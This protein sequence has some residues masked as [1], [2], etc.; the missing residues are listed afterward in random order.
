MTPEIERLCT[1]IAE[2]PVA[3]VILGQNNYSKALL[4]NELLQKP[5]LPVEKEGDTRTYWCLIS[6]H[7]GSKH[8]TAAMKKASKKLPVEVTLNLVDPQRNDLI[9]SGKADLEKCPFK[10]MSTFCGRLEIVEFQCQCHPN[11]C[12][13]YK[14][15]AANSLVVHGEKGP[16]DTTRIDAEE[17]QG[18]WLSPNMSFSLHL[19]KSAQKAFAVLR[20]IRRT[21]SRITRT[22]FKIIYGAYVRPPV[23]Y[24]NPVVY[25]GR[26]KDVILIERVQ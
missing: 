6:I 16:E 25:S 3:F 13:R 4:V 26:T 15:D 7:G 9:D 11:G 22:D 23:E 14:A 19:E 20:M 24:A 1:Q 10:S 8:A 17:D 5:V 18:I 21:F 2:K 12:R